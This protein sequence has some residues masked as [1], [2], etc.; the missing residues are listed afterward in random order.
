M[1]AYEIRKQ[2]RIEIRG[3]IQADGRC[4]FVLFWMANYHPGDPN[5]EYGWRERGQ[6]FYANPDRFRNTSGG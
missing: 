1:N 2:A 4:H 5:G 6:H 3:P